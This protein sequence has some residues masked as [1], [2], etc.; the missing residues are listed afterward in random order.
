[1]PQIKRVFVVINIDGFYTIDVK[2]GITTVTVPPA[3]AFCLCTDGTANGLYAAGGGSGSGGGAFVDLADT[4]SET[5]R[6]SV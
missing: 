2:R 4:P 6:N 1:V 5:V 3:S